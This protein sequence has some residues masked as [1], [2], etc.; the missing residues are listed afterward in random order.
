MVGDHQVG[1]GAFELSMK[2]AATSP[3]DAAKGGE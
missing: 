1:K 2:A 3:A